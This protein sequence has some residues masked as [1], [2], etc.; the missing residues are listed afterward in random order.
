MTAVRDARGGGMPAPSALPY[1]FKG[2]G[3]RA[4]P[5]GAMISAV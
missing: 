5:G 1:H 2:G 3:V 4:L